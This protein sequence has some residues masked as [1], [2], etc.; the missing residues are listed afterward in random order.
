[1]IKKAVILL[2]G[3]GSRLGPSTLSINK[4]ILPIFNKP[5][6]FFP[7]SLL[8][9][10]NIKKFL[11]VVNKG[12]INI[13]K[14]ILGDGR[15]IGIEIKF[16]EQQ[17]PSGVPDA[18]ALAENFTG[19]DRFAVILGDNF[20]YGS[21]LPA[22]IQE[23][24]KKKNI[25]T[26]TYPAQNPSQFGILEL[27]RFGKIKSFREKP[28]KTL[29]NLA[30]TG[31]YVFDK[32]FYKYVKKIKPSK[33]NELEITDVLKIYKKK[34]LNTKLG[35]GDVWFDLGTFEDIFKATNFVKNIQDRQSLQIACLEEISYSNGWVTK[36][37]IKDS[38]DKLKNLSY[39]DYIKKFIK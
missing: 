20:F 4:H 33:R 38:L 29:S 16:V 13:F 15:H 19:K 21:N 36:K 25:L 30:I 8:M 11:F 24:Y 34:I 23:K 18:I 10:T 2:G 14:N 7:L 17:K 26:F 32:D 22:L 1:M 27:D 35:R 6:F 37:K 3:S 5:M 9:L 31:L 28:K 12:E 39:R